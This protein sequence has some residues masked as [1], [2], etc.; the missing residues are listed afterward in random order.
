MY[1]NM[2]N[3][4][5]FES[6]TYSLDLAYSYL[7]NWGTHL[8]NKE[9]LSQIF[10]DSFDRNLADILLQNWQEKNFVDFPE[11]KI[12]SKS[13]INNANGAYAKESKTIYLAEEFLLQGNN[14]SIAAVI[15]EEYG[16]HLDTLLNQT[17]A[18]GDEGAI[19]SSLVRG[20]ELTNEQIQ[21]IRIEDDHA[22]VVLND[23]PIRIEQATSFPYSESGTRVGSTVTFD[24][25]V[26]QGKI[27]LNFQTY[28]IPD[29]IEILYEGNNIYDS[30]FVGTGTEDRVEAT[31]NG[32]SSLVLVRM[33]PNR[34]DPGTAWYFTVNAELGECSDTG[35]LNIEGDFEHNDDENVCEATGTVDVGR[36]DPGATSQL[37]KVESAT[38]KYT[39]SELTVSDGIVYAQINNVEKPLFKGSFTLPFDT[40]VFGSVTDTGNVDDDD[41]TI[42]GLEIEFGKLRLDR[43][44]I[45]LEGSFS[46][47][48]ALGAFNLNLNAPNALIISN[49]DIRIEGGSIAFPDEQ[50]KLFGAFDVTSEDAAIEYTPI[51]SEGN[52]EL[53]VQG[54][55][56]LNTPFLK[57][58]PNDSSGANITLDISGTNYLKVQNGLADINGTFS[59]G[60]IALANNWKLNQLAL[61]VTTQDGEITDAGGTAEI[62][63]P[64]S[65]SPTDTDGTGINVGIGLTFPDS[66]VE[67]DRIR[68]GANDLDIPVGSTGF[69]L[70][71]LDGRVINL[72]PSNDDNIEF[73][74]FLGLTYGPEINLNLDDNFL[75][76][77]NFSAAAVE[78]GTTGSASENSLG[79]SAIVTVVDK[80]IFQVT[81]GADLNWNENSKYFEGRGFATAL[82]GMFTGNA[83]LKFDFN[84]NKFEGSGRTDIAFPET[85]FFNSIPN[86]PLA[87]VNVAS[88]Q[89]SFSYSDDGINSNDFIRAFGTANVFGIG[90]IGAGFQYNFDNSYEILTDRPDLLVPVNATAQLSRT[91]LFSSFLPATNSSN[92]TVASSTILAQNTVRNEFEETYEV[93]SN[94][95]YILLNIIWDDTSSSITPDRVQVEVIDPDGN[96][97]EEA[98][99]DRYE[100]IT[101]V[102]QLTAANHKAIGIKAPSIGEW[103]IRIANQTELGLSDVETSIYRP[104]TQIDPTLEILDVSQ[105]ADGSEVT[106]VY[107]ARDPDTATTFDLYYQDDDRG[108]DFFESKTIVSDLSENDGKGTYV[109]NTEGI[110]PGDYY[111]IG[112][113]KGRHGIR[114]FDSNYSTNPIK[115][116]KEA[117][118]SATITSNI[119]E[120]TVGEEITYTAKISN[121]S[122]EFESQDLQL[123]FGLPEGANLISTS[124]PIAY[125]G[126]QK[127]GDFNT[128]IFKIERL[129]PGEEYDIEIVVSAP[130]TTT[131]STSASVYI[132]SET[133][134]SNLD[135]NRDDIYISI[136]EPKET[137]PFLTLERIDPD[138]ENQQVDLNTRYSYEIVVTNTGDDVATGVVVTENIDGLDGQLNRVTTT[139]GSYSYNRFSD[140]ITANLGSIAPGE[141]ETITIELTAQAAG[142]RYTSS[143]LQ[144]NEKQ[145]VDEITTTTTVKP[146][147][148]PPA[149]LELTQ[150]IDNLNPLVGEQVNI[151]LNLL[152][153]GP[154]IASGIEITNLLPDGLSFVR[155]NAALGNYNST[156]GIWNAGNIR[157]GVRTSL[158]ITALVE[159]AGS[160]TNQA[161]ITF[162]DQKDS[163]STPGNGD[164]TEDDFAAV[165][166]EAVFPN[167]PPTTSGIDN[168]VVTKN[169]PDITFSLFDV[170]DDAEDADTDLIYR[171]ES[172]TNP[173]LFESIELESK[174]GNLILDFADDYIL[175]RADIS[176]SATDPYGESIAADFTVSVVDSGKDKDTLIGDLGNDYLFGDKKEDRLE[177]L[178]GDDTL[179]GDHG[180]DTLIGGIGNDYLEGGKDKDIFVLTVGEGID[181][182]ADFENKKDLLGLN[183]GLTFGQLTILQEGENTVVGIASSKEVLAILNNVDHGSID[184]KDFTYM[185]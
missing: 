155:A 30:N 180:K 83:N 11:I 102:E 73:T 45:E 74:G 54:K 90:N 123:S 115:I 134:D 121:T 39:E 146:I 178:E 176:V 87:G 96:I 177:G 171:L 120:V 150:T 93:E 13:E 169:A 182:I 104:V 5:L 3:I 60:D 51:N 84:N 20:K 138:F 132:I 70:Q 158:T 44:Q 128:K 43:N 63:L 108:Y 117:D 173:D 162:T 25:G 153:Q 23:Q 170:F 59:V 116:T 91:A 94:L 12:V 161:E 135:N 112:Q 107:D 130:D 160:I 71:E 174:S 49:D 181:T 101:V 6:L 53:K 7:N 68:L 125:S 36:S 27:I 19:F 118:L 42:A 172:N 67:L 156:T 103:G 29:R 47:P 33:T 55:F 65:F 61:S 152:N 48:N 92:L 179:I 4:L 148:V 185:V 82:A 69:V 147:P 52:D 86:I 124:H 183:N 149:D 66:G 18:P 88:A 17:D 106:I 50:F 57:T 140:I 32:D 26:T 37:I 97:I 133:Y 56:A 38:A 114:T 77:G 139:Q 46:I 127:G 143:T 151:T 15:L 129:A 72:A 100:N 75:I 98:D 80:N 154:G 34:N 131:P 164:T 95:D 31:F 168:F 110:A 1:F 145:V 109:W 137:K 64:L 85:D 165:T 136:D 144:Y 119:S 78:L 16:H 142:E 76:S 111:V 58:D 141:T 89:F 159:D 175:G 24:T 35:V 2:N 40:P 184:Q 28:R 167:T 113:I 10:G 8:E 22:V 99:F 81:G 62:V 105:N 9:L 21:T 157:D 166:I 126:D 163:D 122:N 41:F 79:G 14:E